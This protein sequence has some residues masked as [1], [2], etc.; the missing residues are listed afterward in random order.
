MRIRHALLATAIAVGA[1][2]GA[3]SRVVAQGSSGYLVIVNA[4]NTASTLP[5]GEVAALFLK[6]VTT[7]PDGSPVAVVDLSE[8]SPVRAAFSRGV[9][10]RPI[11]AVRSYWQQQVFGGKGVPPTQR[12]SD[13]EVVAYVRE[14][15]NAIG[16]VAPTTPLGQGI[17]PLT[18]VGK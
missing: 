8:K 1:L 9:I 15:P 7:W 10:G 11:A 3:P 14:N 13:V 6:Q 2:S 12:M 16:Y 5:R 18:I 4:S 17:R